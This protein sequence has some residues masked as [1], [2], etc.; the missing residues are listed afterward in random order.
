MAKFAQK[1]ESK[2]TEHWKPSAKEAKDLSEKLSKFTKKDNHYP[3]ELFLESEGIISFDSF[4]RWQV[5][6][7]LQYKKYNEINS[8]REYINDKEQ[9]R[10]FDAFPE[11]RE[12]YL[13][14]I[15]TLKESIRI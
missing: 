12:N 2:E 15:Q 8:L 6:N 11:E 9:D 3:Y 1:I 13:A 4:G 14:E 10:Y 5:I 7:P